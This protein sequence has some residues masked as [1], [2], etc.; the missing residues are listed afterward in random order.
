MGIH[1]D[2]ALYHPDGKFLQDLALWSDKG[3]IQTNEVTVFPFMSYS[4]ALEAF[5]S[6]RHWKVV[7]NFEE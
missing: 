5:E 4:Q 6:K 3:S 7:V 1:Y 2:W